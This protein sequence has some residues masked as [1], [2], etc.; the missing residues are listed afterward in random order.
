M[1]EQMKDEIEQEEDREEIA[2]EEQEEL[3]KE[4]VEESDPE[5]EAEARKY[6]WRPKSEF[7]RDPSGW[8]DAKR[9]LEIPQTQVKMLRDSKRA[10]EKELRELRD[11]VSR[12]EGTT[13]TAIERVREQEK[14]AYEAKLS[15]FE[16]SKREA[17]EVG[18]MAR[19]DAIQSQQAKL[20]APEP[21]EQPREQPRIH[22]DL[23][24]YRQSDAGAWIGNS[25]AT[26][27]GYAEI[28]RNPSIKQLPVG[29][30]LQ[31]VE[32]RVREHFPELFPQQQQRAS[33]VDGG[34]VAGFQRRGKGADDLPAEARQVGQDFVKEGVFKNLE[35]YAREYFGQE[36]GR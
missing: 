18:D 24:V 9:F 30:Q 10:S 17:A 7:D 20:R 2:E 6:G 35:D 15:E 19:Y 5:S 22:P 11:Q 36:A 34:G 4:P 12:I 8:V 21:I 29:K 31:W 26:S 27:F 3:V 14:L 1:G 16:R 28:E 25:D 32:G 23:E 13:K 33:K